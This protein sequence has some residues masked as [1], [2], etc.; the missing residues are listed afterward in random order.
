MRAC[1]P[2][3]GFCMASLREPQQALLEGHV[4]AFRS[5]AWPT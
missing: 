2:G 3:A 1:H 5:S 4:E